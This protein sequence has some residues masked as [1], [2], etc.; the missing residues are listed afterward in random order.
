VIRTVVTSLLALLT[1][2]VPGHEPQLESLRRFSWPPLG[3]EKNLGQADSQ[4]E[5]VSLG[6]DSG[7]LLARAGE[8]RVN[9]GR[10]STSMKLLGANEQARAEGVGEVVSRSNYFLGNDPQQW[11]TNIPNISKVIA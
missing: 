1:V 3:F 6:G 2:P 9:L 11:R 10:H 7:L 5:F 4:I 8:V